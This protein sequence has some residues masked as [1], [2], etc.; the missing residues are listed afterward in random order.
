MGNKTQEI[1]EP[2]VLCLNTHLP[3]AFAFLA[4]DQMDQVWPKH[5][6]VTVWRFSQVETFFFLFATYTPIYFHG[7]VFRFCV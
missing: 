4:L 5:C 2:G 7:T 3:G 1:L 6:D